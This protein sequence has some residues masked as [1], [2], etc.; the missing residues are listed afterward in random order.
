MSPLTKVF[1]IGRITGSGR[2]NYMAKFTLP[3]PFKRY[4]VIPD[5]RYLIGQFT[6][7]LVQIVRKRVEIIDQQHVHD[8]PAFKNGAM[9]WSIA[10]FLSLISRYSRPACES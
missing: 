4:F 2:N 7:I 9:A 8:G 6:Q 5:N 3:N 1:S 10:A